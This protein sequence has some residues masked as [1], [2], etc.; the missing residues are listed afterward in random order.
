MAEADRFKS[1]L[2]GEALVGDGP[3][4]NRV[5]LVVGLKESSME[6][7]FISVLASPAQGHTPLLAL[8]EPHLRVKHSTLIINKVA[9]KGVQQGKMIYGPV[10]TAVIKVVIDCIFEG[11]LP[12]ELADDLLILASVFV[13]KE[14][15]NQARVYDFNRRAARQAIERA[16]NGW[17]KVE[18]VLARKDYASRPVD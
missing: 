3:K 13:E 9:I 8:L 7:A 4:A 10:H 11:F 5:D 6:Q 14:A 2:I 12:K 16:A 15:V 1:V 17:T 18:E